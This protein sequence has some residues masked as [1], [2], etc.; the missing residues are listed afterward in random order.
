MVFV[1]VV[2]MV[3][4]LNGDDSTFHPSS[5]NPKILCANKVM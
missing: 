2:V 4:A 5:L 3:R 1:M